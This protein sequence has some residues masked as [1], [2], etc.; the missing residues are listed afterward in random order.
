MDK[1]F[2]GIP[3][4]V[5]KRSR[6]EMQLIFFFASPQIINCMYITGQNITRSWKYADLKEY[7]FPIKRM[8]QIYFE[9][10]ERKY[11]KL[12][13]SINLFCTVLF[14]LEQDSFQLVL[15]L[16]ALCDIVVADFILS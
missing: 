12:T 7:K 9:M 3:K 8:I 11:H 14:E 6:R 16:R 1:I 2:I 5:W 10:C 4:T 15:F 13:N